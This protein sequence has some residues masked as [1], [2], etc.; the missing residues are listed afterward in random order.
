MLDGL[1][2]DKTKQA[3]PPP[4]TLKVDLH[5]YQKCALAWM[6]DRERGRIGPRGGLLA[7]WLQKH[8]SY[9]IVLAAAWHC[10]RNAARALHL[11]TQVRLHHAISSIHVLSALQASHL[12]MLWLTKVCSQP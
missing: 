2:Q 12:P 10:P 7:G 9:F 1:K 3:T 8:G 5:P 11:W 4:G 6:L